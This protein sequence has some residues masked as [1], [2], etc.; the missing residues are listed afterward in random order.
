M[1]NITITKDLK[2]M[3][4]EQVFDEKKAKKSNTKIMSSLLLLLVLVVSIPLVI[5]AELNN[6]FNKKLII[7]CP[8]LNSTDRLL[9]IDWSQLRKKDSKVD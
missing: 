4:E 9:N 6:E 7:V 1:K 5:K 8:E 3:S 2:K